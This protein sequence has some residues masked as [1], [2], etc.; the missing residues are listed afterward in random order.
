MRDTNFQRK[1][2][3]AQSVN[4]ERELKVHCCWVGR[5]SD[6]HSAKRKGMKLKSKNVNL[7]EKTLQFSQLDVGSQIILVLCIDTDMDH[8][9]GA[10]VWV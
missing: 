2:S 6:T 10:G 8:V 3:I 4:D 5:S 7:N 1:K 9:L